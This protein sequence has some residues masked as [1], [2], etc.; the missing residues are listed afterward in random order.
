[1]CRVLVAEDDAE[2]R[3]LVIE[4]LWKDGHSVLEV[5]DGRALLEMLLR[6]LAR[7]PGAGI[8][9]VV[10]D[11]RMPGVSGLEVAEHLACAR[12]RFPFVLMTAFGDVEVRR[13]ADAIGAV[14]LEKP[15]SLAE[16]RNAVLKLAV[17]L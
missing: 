8:D 4:A 17:A 12:Q 9:V 14:L 1:M 6:A 11:L 7:E 2:M 5:V 13:R 10:S 16:L 3:R 15:L